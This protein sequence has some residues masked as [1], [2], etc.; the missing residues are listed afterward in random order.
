MIK[1]EF[2]PILGW[3]F[4]SL[5]SAAFLG[6]QIAMVAKYHKSRKCSGPDTA[7]TATVHEPFVAVH[8]PIAAYHDIEQDQDAETFKNPKDLDIAELQKLIRRKR[9][10]D[11]NYSCR[12]LL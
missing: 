5:G 10:E 9:Q 2:T 12:R 3:I 1:G 8:E 6:G 7:T 11:S 4:L